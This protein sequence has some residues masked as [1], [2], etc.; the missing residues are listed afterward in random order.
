[1]AEKWQPQCGVELEPNQFY[2]SVCLDLLKDPVT[3]QCGHTYC[4]SCIEGCWDQEKE[5]GTYSCPQCR[6]AFSPRPVLGRNNMLAEVVEKLKR[7]V[8]QQA[9]PASPLAPAG[10]TDIACDFCCGTKRNKASMS[11]LTCLASYCPAHLEPHH[12]FP[13]L[14]LH[15]LVSATVPLKEKMCTKHNKLMEVYCKTDQ[16][17]ICYLCTMDDHRRHSTVS[18]AAERADKQVKLGEIQSAVKRRFQERQEELNELV[19]AV[20]DFEICCQT[21][22]KSSDELFD[23]LISSIQ[24]K[25]ALIKELIE[26]RQK[27]A[28]AEA[29]D[30][31]MQLK[32][33][34]ATLGRRDDDL[35][36]LSHTVDHIH[37]IQIFQSLSI[38]C[39]SPDLPTGAVVRPKRSMEAVTDYVSDLADDMQN[40]L[41]TTWPEIS[42][43]VS[44]TDVVLPPVPKTRG[45]LLR[46]HCPL[47]LD[48]NSVNNCFVISQESK[49]VTSDSKEKYYLSHLD[50]FGGVKQVLCREG[51]TGRCYWEVSWSGGAWSLAASY[52]NISRKL[53]ESE[54]GKNDKSWC[55][56]CSADGYTFRHNSVAKAVSGPRTS[57][58]G[59]YLDYRSGT[60]S[61]YSISDTMTLLHKVCTVF[62]QPLY[63]GLGLKEGSSGCYAEVKKL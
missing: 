42:A 53:S 26:T 46:Y 38:S 47:T 51:L 45:E 18:A 40:L 5:K 22:V 63:P 6:E 39:E 2:C 27:T 14:K 44:V 55:L 58:I 1:M 3:I 28:I 43:T 21:A 24:N 30:L 57:Q 31:Q 9:R 20:K 13:V 11:C 62:T 33:E 60:L 15:Q 23:E 19:Q 7:T 56:E 4:R 32:E 29:E 52:K 48:P 17:C 12:S 49:R 37:F 41:E 10:P 36:Q 59:V 25:R 50:R 35:E 8:S 54:F 34:I 16:R 61:F